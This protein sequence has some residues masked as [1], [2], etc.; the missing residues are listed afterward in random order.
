MSAV[1]SDID[2]AARATLAVTLESRFYKSIELTAFLLY[3]AG[4]WEQQSHKH[5]QYH[6]ALYVHVALGPPHIDGRKVAVNV[7]VCVR[8]MAI[9]QP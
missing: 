8:K 7:D 4:T 9:S 3:G 6:P 2:V 5:G 1:Q